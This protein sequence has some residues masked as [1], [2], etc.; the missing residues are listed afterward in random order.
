MAEVRTI[1]RGSTRWIYALLLIVLLGWVGYVYFNPRT[2]KKPAT[3]LGPD[4]EPIDE[5]RPRA[6]YTPYSTGTPYTMRTPI[7]SSSPLT[8]RTPPPVEAPPLVETPRSASTVNI[9]RTFLDRVGSEGS[10]RTVDGLTVIARPGEG[11]RVMSM[12]RQNQILWFAADRDLDG[13][14]DSGADLSHCY[15]AAVVPCGDRV[16]RGP[17]GQGAE[18]AAEWQKRFETALTAQ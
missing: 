3:E 2:A 5:A 7:A 12:N 1:R 11:L 18:F 6:E 17:G 8:A 16:F 14:V 15:P 9:S 13:R 4:A 10:W